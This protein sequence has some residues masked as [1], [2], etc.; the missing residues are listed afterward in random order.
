MKIKYTV[1]YNKNDK[2][3]ILYKDVESSHSIGCF[4]VME[5]TKIECYKKRKL[6]IGG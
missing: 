3:Y 5:G 6:L 4:K 1:H 2:K